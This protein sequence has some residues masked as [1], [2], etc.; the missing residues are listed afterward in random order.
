MIGL[1]GLFLYALYQI[2]SQFALALAS[3]MLA[4][5]QKIEKIGVLDVEP[6]FG[7][8]SIHSSTKRLSKRDSTTMKWFSV[9]VRWTAP[10][11][12]SRT[13]GSYGRSMIKCWGKHRKRMRLPSGCWCSNTPE[14]QKPTAWPS[15]SVSVAAVKADVVTLAKTNGLASIS[16]TDAVIFW[17]WVCRRCGFLHYVL[18]LLPWVLRR[19]LRA[20]PSA[21]SAM[22]HP[23]ACRCR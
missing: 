9:I 19:K 8:H 1:N 2:F 14:C 11:S 18:I 4:L 20:Q 7:G 23:G 21:T 3:G 15:A 17:R 16:M 13:S 22:L 12:L 5:L 6:A 10:S